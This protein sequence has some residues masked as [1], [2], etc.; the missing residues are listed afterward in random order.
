MF[1]ALF[2]EKAVLLSMHVSKPTQVF[3]DVIF[4]V[5]LMNPRRDIFFGKSKPRDM[6]CLVLYHELYP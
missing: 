1:L 3:T 5:I 4:N 6:D 2:K